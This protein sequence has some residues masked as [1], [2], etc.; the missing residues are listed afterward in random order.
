[1]TRLVVLALA[2]TPCVLRAADPLP[3]ELQY[4]PADAAGFVHVDFKRLWASPLGQS[5][6]TATAPEVARLTAAW[7]AA[8]GLTLD[9]VETV[10][11][12]V[13]KDDNEG[14]F[15]HSFAVIVRTGKPFDRAGV[16]RAAKTLA[17]K[18]ETVVVK[19]HV[20]TVK[21]FDRPAWRLDL[22][23]P[24]RLIYSHDCEP[25]ADP[26]RPDGPLTPL[27]HAAAAQPLAAG[28]AFASLSKYF[29][30]LSDAGGD[31]I[32]PDTAILKSPTALVVG[33]LAAKELVLTAIVR[34]PN[35]RHAANVETALDLVRR[36]TTAEL[37]TWA[38]DPDR[39]ARVK[40]FVEFAVKHLPAVT[41][42]TDGPDA[43]ATVAL[44]TDLPAGKLLDVAFDPVKADERE[45]RR[46]LFRIAVALHA[47][48]DLNGFLPP[49]HHVSRKGK[50]T[51]SWR[52]LL[53]PHLGEGELYK[54][55]KLDEPWDGDH[56][57][58]VSKENPMP[59]V[60]ALPGVSKAGG[61][62]T[63]FRVFFGKGA[64]WDVDGRLRLPASFPDGTSNTLALVTAATAVP[65]TKPDEL[66]FDPDADMR[67]LLLFRHG[68]CPVA[69]IDGGTRLLR[70]TVGEMTMKHLIMR[71]DG[72]VIGGDF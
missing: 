68:R 38:A 22:S 57:A 17:E 46:R 20:V 62:D 12:F 44:P 27:L 71:A 30:L 64:G 72:F 67:P 3:V 63:H 69:M 4:V 58:N 18:T 42:A 15:G 61:T 25:A 37:K 70:K 10:T 54:K 39:G 33:Q 8:T 31:D 13:N 7:T 56:S 35:A 50:T 21:R 66:E 6:R 2:I 55:F 51:F 59:E 34:G 9:D 32:R 40:P 65:W 29:R 60:F 19:G 43:T 36:E 16:I 45:A 14:R 48:H 26:K 24:N 52:V 41:L 1:M 28:V 11:A 47:Y 23:D 49:S 53:L 5:A